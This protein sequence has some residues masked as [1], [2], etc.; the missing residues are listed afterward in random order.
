[1][2]DVS[3]EPK[4]RPWVVRPFSRALLGVAGLALASL[5]VIGTETYNLAHGSQDHQLIVNQQKE[6]AAVQR[7]L[8]LAEGSQTSKAGVEDDQWVVHQ[9]QQLC[10]AL[11]QRPSGLHGCQL[12]PLPPALDHLVNPPPGR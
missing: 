9:I 1:M 4:R 3:T 6:L 7:I 2:T 10:I 12:V 8:A 5:G 11:Q